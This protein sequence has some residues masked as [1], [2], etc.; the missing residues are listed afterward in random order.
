MSTNKIDQV[1]DLSKS[2]QLLNLSNGPN[3]DT[4][5]SQPNDTSVHKPLSVHSLND[6]EDA[7]KIDRNLNDNQLVKSDSQLNEDNFVNLEIKIDKDLESLDNIKTGA[8]SLDLLNTPDI[9]PLNKTSLNNLLIDK[10]SYK[11]DDKLVD[12]SIENLIDQSIDSSIDK[13]FNKA[14]NSSD[15]ISNKS[16]KTSLN[17]LSTPLNTSL[18][19]TSSLIELNESTNEKLKEKGKQSTGSIDFLPNFSTNKNPASDLNRINIG[20]EDE[21]IID[22]YLPS[23]F[24]SIFYYIFVILTF[25]LL[26]IYCETKLPL[27]IKFTHRKCSLKE[28]TVVILKD[29]KNEE[30]VEKVIKQNESDY[31]YLTSDLVY[32][33]HKKLKYIWQTEDEQ[34]TRLTGLESVRCDVIFSYKHGLTHQEAEEKFNLYGP[35]SIFI[36]VQPLYKIIVESTKNPFYIYQVVHVD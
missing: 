31:D 1:Q 26:L 8:N 15:K 14:T 4:V 18:D 34:F 33:Y 23:T 6:L 21:M 19:K 16:N 28:A 10:S 27:K 35:N 25:G 29:D 9:E 30:F 17:L 12:S 22:G 5:Y 32:F 24:K 3:Q 13:S 20:L 11:S 36:D 2:D 7:I